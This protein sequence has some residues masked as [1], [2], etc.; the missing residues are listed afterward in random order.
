MVFEQIP[1]RFWA[2]DTKSEKTHAILKLTYTWHK[3]GKKQ[4]KEIYT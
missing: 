4:I 3:K 1:P 2:S